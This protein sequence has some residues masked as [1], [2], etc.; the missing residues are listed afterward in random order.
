VCVC[1]SVCALSPSVAPASW[2]SSLP[3]PPPPALLAVQVRVAQSSR[4]FEHFRLNASALI[5]SNPAV[6]LSLLGNATRSVPWSILPT[7]PFLAV[8]PAGY[9]PSS[10]S[11]ASAGSQQWICMAQRVDQ[12][13]VWKQVDGSDI[14]LT[15]SPCP[16]GR[17]CPGGKI[18]ECPQGQYAP[19]P[20]AAQ[21]TTCPACC[22][23]CDALSGV[24]SP[25]AL[26][27]CLI[28]GQCYRHGQAQ[29]SSNGCS[30]CDISQA[31]D[32]WSV[33]SQSSH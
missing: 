12:V 18:Q 9:G 11:L 20:A 2:P 28:S 5:D 17:F 19:Q 3:C 31:N 33:F 1:V 16:R 7:L 27:G 29:P 32:A 4:T 24:C 14:N 8:C 13:G 26:R 30:R 21:C 15:C 23:T 10:G 25:G 6:E 22:D